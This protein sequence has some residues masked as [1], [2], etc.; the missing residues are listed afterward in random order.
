[1][2]C[3]K[4]VEQDKEYLSLVEETSTLVSDVQ[5]E[6][7]KKII[8]AIKLE[9]RALNVALNGL[10]VAHLR[11]TV[12]SVLKCTPETRAL[13]VDRFVSTILTIYGEKP[14]KYL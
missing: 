2:R 14:L 1:M 7:K 11:Q 12:K 10:Y 13:E 8:F 9:I 6:F 4:I 5:K 3:S